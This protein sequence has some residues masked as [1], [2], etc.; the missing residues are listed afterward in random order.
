MLIEIEI[1]V[2]GI[3]EWIKTHLVYIEIFSTTY[4]VRNLSETTTRGKFN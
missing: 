3:V 4:F 1:V 2:S